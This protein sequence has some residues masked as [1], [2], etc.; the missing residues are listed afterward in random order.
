M[1]TFHEKVT[2]VK[3]LDEYGNIVTVNLDNLTS[4]TLSIEDH[5]SIVNILKRCFDTD[6]IVLEYRIKMS[7]AHDEYDKWVS[8][9]E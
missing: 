4:E 9:H 5:Y 1:N 8:V 3:F 7:S 2:Q 6:V